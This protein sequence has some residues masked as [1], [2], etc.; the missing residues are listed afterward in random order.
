MAEKNKHSWLEISD[1]KVNISILRGCSQRVSFVWSGVKNFVV[2]M[3]E[4]KTKEDKR[5][6]TTE[7]GAG[8][9][10][11]P[12]KCCKTFFMNSPIVEV[13]VLKCENIWLFTNVISNTLGLLAFSFMEFWNR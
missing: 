13:W 2:C 3:R 5:C 10:T 4:E 11:S 12:Y 1:I 7:R 8:G 9:Q 6:K